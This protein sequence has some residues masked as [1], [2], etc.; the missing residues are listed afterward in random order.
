MTKFLVYN[1]VYIEMHENFQKQSYRNR[2]MIYG[3]NGPLALVI[4]V[5]KKRSI[6]NIITDIRIDY[7][8]DWQ[9]IHWKSL[10]SAYQNSPFFEFY[11]DELYEMIF[12]K[13]RFLVDFD[14]KLLNHICRLLSIDE[15]YLMSKDYLNN[16]ELHDY[17]QSISPKK[18]LQRSDRFFQ[19]AKYQ[20]VFAERFGFIPNMSVVDLIFN[21][22]PYSHRILEESIKRGH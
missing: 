19:P 17:R 7:D 3:A 14:L 18:R 9:N 12:S 2:C 11:K 22:G 13:D 5:K 6:K 8:T 4:P 16:D 21:V 15:S 1:R 20:Q 10:V